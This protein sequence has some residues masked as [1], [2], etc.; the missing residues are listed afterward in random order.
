MVFV[1]EKE[2]K[3][4]FWFCG[5]HFNLCSYDRSSSPHYI[6]MHPT[7][8]SIYL[9]AAAEYTR[10]AELAETSDETLP[11]KRQ[12]CH[13]L[14]LDAASAWT[15]MG[16]RGR[17]AESTMKAAFGLIM[18]T[19][20][21]TAMDSKALKSVEE[22]IETYVPDPLN[23]KANYRRTGVS[24][25]CDP[26]T[27]DDTAATANATTTNNNLELAKQNIITDAFAHE[28]LFKVSNDLIKRRHYE[29]ALYAHGAGTATLEHEGFATI[30]LFRAYV[31]T[32]IITLA[33][34]DT[35]AA[36]RDFQRVHLQNTQYLSSRECALEEDLIRAC[37]AMDEEALE[38]VRS[39]SGSH[40]GGMAN[41][42]LTVRELVGEIRVSGRI[43][44]KKPSATPKQPVP[45]PTQQ[46]QQQQPPKQ[47]ELSG[48][49]L[50][51]DTDAGF[52]E[53]DDIMNQMGLNEEDDDDGWED[54]DDDDDDDIDLT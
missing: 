1:C 17:S 44:K 36:S 28:T 32:T 21:K 23:R 48:K 6:P 27:S 2:M 10:A 41:L 43:K 29:S 16:E 53:M 50:T 37:D 7:L 30:S 20:T 12:E 38:E 24:A 51:Q 33:M 35:V 25:Y 34:G 42:D 13:K 26:N 9:S 14:H 52:D 18:G 54:D 40:R 45:T 4:I 47:K 5:M 3:S 19:D 31:S 49:E 11:R 8:L 22:A 39:K 15:Q 46:Q